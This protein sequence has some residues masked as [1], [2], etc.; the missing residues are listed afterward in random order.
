ME[1]SSWYA[2][3]APGRT[4]VVVTGEVD[5]ES[6]PRLRESLASELA[7]LHSGELVVDA[8]GVTFCDSSGLQAFVATHRRAGLLGTRLVLRVTPGGRFARFLE[9]A[10]VSE[11][12]EIEAAA[13]G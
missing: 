12:F 6:G 7:Q 2:E 4:T 13:R 11:L 8:T 9:L 5:L 10:G 1:L 3:H